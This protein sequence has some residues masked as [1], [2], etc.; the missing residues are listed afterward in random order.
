MNISYLVRL[1]HLKPVLEE[2]GP[3]RRCLFCCFLSSFIALS[4]HLWQ[5]IYLPK[6]SAS[7]PQNS[8]GLSPIDIPRFHPDLNQSVSLYSERS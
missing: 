8:H 1:S 2:S 6:V 4:R 7:P 3:L 5:L